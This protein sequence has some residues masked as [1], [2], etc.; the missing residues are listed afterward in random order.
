MAAVVALL[1]PSVLLSTSTVRAD[2]TTQ[3]ANDRISI[4]RELPAAMALLNQA[5]AAVAAKD[6][7]QAASLF[8]RARAEAPRKALP[9]RRYCETLAALGRREQAI[10]ACEAAKTIGEGP[11]EMRATVTAYLSGPSAPTSDQL[12]RA[13]FYASY[14]KKGLPLLALGHA[15]VCDVALKVDDGRLLELCL[16]DLLRVAP[17]DPE[18]KRIQAAIAAR[19]PW[20]AWVVFAL[21]GLGALATVAH[22]LVRLTHPLAKQRPAASALALLLGTS[23]LLVAA[24]LG[25][26]PAAYAEASPTKPTTTSGALPHYPYAPG[27]GRSF[28]SPPPALSA[29]VAPS[30][31]P[32]AAA[33]ASALT[34]EVVKKGDIGAVDID[35][36]NPEA[37]VPGPEKASLNPLEYGYIVQDVVARAEAASQRGD[38]PAEVRFYRALVKMVPDRAIGFSKL[39]AAYEKLGD[40]DRAIEACVL[41]VSTEGVKIEDHAHLARLVLGNPGTISD[42]HLTLLRNV[43]AH[44]RSDP[45]SAI[46]ADHISCELALRTSD[47]AMLEACTAGLAAKAPRDPKTVSF[48]WALA[49]QKHDRVEALRLIEQAKQAGVF[50]EGI[51]QMQVLTE[52][53]L[54][55]ARSWPLWR[56]AL[57]LAFA[58]IVVFAMV[59]LRRRTSPPRPA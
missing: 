55:S 30:P 58:S 4:A 48:Q 49:V 45:N 10:A 37:T 18:T 35:E 20:G 47:Q 32:V 31:P 19:R 11:L 56:L 13:W 36:A 14:I 16:G 5:E 42:K 34:P 33:K 44:L 52:S 54:G 7:E 29:P 46:A 15:A 1:V 9:G 22:A 40:R 6:L 2:V 28:G 59:T 3:D 38:V 23:G 24:G 12:A 43:I 41:A 8:A 50:P 53:K 39:C 26:V 25:G 17:G 21:I 27:A 57:G 51:K